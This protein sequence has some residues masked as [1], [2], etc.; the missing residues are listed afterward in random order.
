MPTLVTRGAASVRGF[1]FAGTSPVLPDPYFNYTTLL[2]HGNGTNGGQNNTFQDSSTNN[3]TITRNGNTT[4]GTFSPFSQT[5][6]SN[7]FDGSGDY[8][9]STLTGQTFGTGDFTVEFWVKFDSIANTG[10]L[11]TRVSG[12]SSSTWCVQIYNNNL[13]WEGSGVAN[14]SIP[15]SQLQLSTWMHFAYTRVSGVMRVYMNGVQYGSTASVTNNYTSTRLDIGGAVFASISWLSGYMSNVRLVKGSAV[16]TGNFTPP[17]AP[18]T[19]ISGTVFLSCQ[20]NRFIDNSSSAFSISVGGTPSVQAFSPFAPT[21]A[22]SASTV[23]GSGYF[24][25]SG[26][27]LSVAS[28]SNIPKAN[29]AFTVESW[30]RINTTSQVDLFAWGEQTSS[31]YTAATFNFGGTGN[32]LFFW[33]SNDLQANG[34]N[35]SDGAWHHVAFTYDG[36]TRAIYL[37]GVRVASDTPAAHNVT[38]TNNL[39]IGYRPSGTAYS[40]NGYM[41]GF[42]IVSNAAIYSGTTYTIPTAPPT[43]TVS[44]G[45][46]ST[47][48]NFT[49]AAII[50]NTAKNVLE[51]VADA[52]ISTTQSKF[53]GASLYFD[54]NGD[55]LT[56]PN[57][58]SVA[59]G[60]GNFTVEFWAYCLDTSS[61]SRNIFD[62]RSINTSG[63]GMFFANSGTSSFAF[64][65]GLSPYTL[66]TVGGRVNNQWQHVAVVRSGSTITIYVDGVSQGTLSNST[67]WSDSNLRIS[68]FVDTQSSIYAYYGYLDDFRITKGIARYT[69]NFTPQTSQW[70]DQ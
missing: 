68:G 39:T 41:S 43:T 42:R 59:F 48:L 53:G 30:V 21:A 15:T 23:G 54:G 58:Q 60:T 55:S 49:N 9:Q 24:D 27:Y 14:L 56:A 46:V 31:K 63:N 35:V 66:L 17:T 1:G 45:T 11:D 52:Q 6:W 4:Q 18:L 51:T 2:L 38:V 7:Y 70:Q 67:N 25:G 3:F 33:W 12:D 47:L 13:S 28:N 22:Y 37:D 34:T 44:S 50:D 16:Y 57:N 29:E 19:A 26:D 8:L 5:G 32:I 62:T 40:F 61:N 10:I 36:T 20:S 65:Y 64:G 69:S